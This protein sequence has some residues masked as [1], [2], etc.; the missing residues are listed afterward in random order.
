[1]MSLKI[2]FVGHLWYGSTGL[3]RLEALSRLG[4]RVTPLDTTEP[5]SVHPFTR[6]TNRVFNRLGY[7]LDLS[8]CN[9]RLVDAIHLETFDMVWI[10]K[11]MTIKPATLLSI[12]RLSPATLIIGYSPDDMAQRH[13][14]SRYFLDD[15]G[16]YDYYLTTKT[17]NVP[18]LRAMGVRQPLF[19]ANAY[20]PEI[21]RPL[22]LST[23]ERAALGG[24]VGFIGAFEDDRAAHILALAEAGIKVR[25]WGWPGNRRWVNKHPN[26]KIE[27]K[28][29]WG[30]EY[31]KA[32][33]SFDIN[34]CFLRKIN[35]DRQTTRSVE[36]PACGGFMLAERTD[37]HLELFREGVE[38]EFFGSV[39]ELVKKVCYYLAHPEER[40]RIAQAGLRRCHDAGY[41]NDQRLQV[42]LSLLLGNEYI[43]R[44]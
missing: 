21:H 44:I 18:E 31:A 35:R 8:A 40:Q 32:I 9:Q 36:I 16:Y 43:H 28:P 25:W 6:F 1:M 24:P 10:D 30:D 5:G 3:Q 29:L 19:I 22:D 37:E 41:S 13:N 7:P 14:Q 23:A 39:E 34:L 17:Y 27:K 11:G 15:L 2:L 20:A 4:H 38:A 12:K 33:N 26:L 42:M